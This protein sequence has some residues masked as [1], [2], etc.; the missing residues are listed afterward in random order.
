MGRVQQLV[1]VLMVLISL[2]LG[3]YAWVLGKRSMTEKPAE[4]SVPRLNVV[5]AAKPIAAGV[6]IAKDAI[7]VEVMTVKAGRRV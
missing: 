7:K 4:S 5:V 6:P 2:G 1:A 3:W